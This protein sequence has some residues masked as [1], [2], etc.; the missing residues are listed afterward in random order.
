MVTSEAR[1]FAKTGGL[2]DVSNALSRALARLG[3]QV[4]IVLPR[5]RGTDSQAVS[6]RRI[7]VPMGA[8]NYPVRLIERHIEYGVNAIL[9]DAPALFDRDGLYGDDKG[10]FG[11]NAFRFGL[12]GRAALEYARLTAASGRHPSVVHAHDWQGSFASIFLRTVLRDDPFFRQTRSVLTIHNLAFQGNFDRKELPFIGLSQDLYH[13]GLLEFW[14]RASSLKGAVVL[15]DTITTVSPT[16]AREIVL[17]EFG[18]G[19]NGILQNR[20]ADLVGILNGIDVDAWNPTTDRYLPAHF[21]PATLDRKVEVKRALLEYVA[22]PHDDAA[23]ARPV[24]GIVTRLTTQKGCDLMAA[25]ADRLMSLDAT[26]VMLGSGDAWCEDMW[27][28]LATRHP[29]RVAA[30]VGFDEQLSH[31]IEGGADMFLMPSWYEPCG[32]NQMY[33]Q[34]YGTVPVVRATGGLVDSVV[35]AGE[36]PKTGTGFKFSDYNPDGLMGALG[37]AFDAFRDPKRWRALQ[38]NAMKQDFSWDVSAREYVKVYRGQKTDGIRQGTDDHGRQL[39]SN[40][41]RRKARAR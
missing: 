12:L 9:V 41:Q 3:H 29:Q 18:F 39:R 14:G 25:A 34:R 31:L 21:D 37:R 1:P 35:D 4:T 16:Y 24:I 17:P 6:E 36:F 32:L 15:S 7:Q 27:R 5:Y 11:D 19:F 38:K 33:S 22:L 2:A 26:W 8:G 20:A 13:P 40:D 23:M 10:E 28:R 30:V